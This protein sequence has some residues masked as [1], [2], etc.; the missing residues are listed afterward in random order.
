[1][2]LTQIVKGKSGVKRGEEM[3]DREM[4]RLKVSSGFCGSFK[5]M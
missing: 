5:T 2:F 1:M 3:T 4:L